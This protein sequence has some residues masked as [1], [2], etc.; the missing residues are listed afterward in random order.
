MMQTSS[1]VPSSAQALWE[2]EQLPFPP[3]PEHLA[4]RLASAGPHVF[5]TRA[6]A[7]T[8]YDLNAFVQE[9][10][11]DTKPEDYAVVGFDG[12]GI[13]SW[14]AHYY[15]VN[16]PLALFLQLPWGGVYDDAKA[17]R[18]EIVQ[19]FGWAAS[20]ESLMAQAIAQQKIPVGWRLAVVASRFRNSGWRWIKPAED[21]ARAQ[22]NSPAGMKAALIALLTDIANG[23][24]DLKSSN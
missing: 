19:M 7:F 9:I 23:R 18:E 22:W 2:S 6:L 20:I 8:P 21:G 24:V 11:D 14:A 10:E 3:V 15:V 4:A 13:N 12:H 1:S 17:A 16:G 5:S